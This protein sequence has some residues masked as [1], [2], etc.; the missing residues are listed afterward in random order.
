MNDDG[1]AYVL[2]TETT[3]FAY[4]VNDRIIEIGIV[5]IQN[6]V[7]TGRELHY[8]INPE[9]PISPG[10]TAVCGITD[11]MVKDAPVFADIADE[12]WDFIGNRPIIAHNAR[13]DMNFINMERGRLGLAPMENKIIDTLK[14]SRKI[15]GSGGN[16]LDAL[17]RKY[18]V[19]A[20]GRTKKGGHGALLDAKLLVQVYY[21]LKNTPKSNL[22]EVG[23]E[24]E[25][26]KPKTNF[27]KTFPKR[28][29][30]QI[31][32]KEA[33]KHEEICSINNIDFKE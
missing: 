10:A 22:T 24:L 19:V 28:P 3:G 6:D 23:S 4:K 21:H 9:R 17:C 5:E 33:Q 12:V 14:Q 27:L 15:H 11:E 16:S 18:K 20:T 25:E 1:L 31:S 26:T 8:R 2:D 32:N 7:P 29:P 13:F 30:V